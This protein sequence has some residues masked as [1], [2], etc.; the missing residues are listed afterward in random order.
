MNEITAIITF[1]NKENRFKNLEF[2]LSWLE[3]ISTIK[4]II[5][6]EQDS[7]PS[8]NIL[9]SNYSK[10]SYLFFY[11]PTY[12][13]KSI[14][15]N[16]GAKFSKNS[17]LF[18]TDSDIFFDFTKIED[19]LLNWDFDVMSPYS[20]I[21][22]LNLIESNSLITN[23]KIVLDDLDLPFRKEICIAGGSFFI[24]KEKY[25]KNGG[26]NEEF[27]SWG[28]EDDYFSIVLDKNSNNLKTFEQK[29]YHLFHDRDIYSTSTHQF[30]KSN[31]SILATL[32]YLNIKQINT[33][34]SI[35]SKYKSD[36]ESF[37]ECK[38]GDYFQFKNALGQRESS[39]NYSI[40]NT[41]GF[42]GKYQF[43]YERLQDLGLVTLTND[44][45]IWNNGLSKDIFLNNSALQEKVFDLHCIDILEKLIKNYSNFINFNIKNTKLTLSG[46]IAGVH[47]LGF[48][49]LDKRLINEEST[50]DA[51]G[52]NIDNYLEQFS[53]YKICTILD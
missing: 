23:N 28:G 17:K 36:L 16:L 35:S 34:S 10:L 37:V 50:N 22:D 39:N 45:Y 40:V 6:I 32:N 19:E 52:T 33:L 3:N 44:N 48:Q 21:F 11:N 49:N 13:N 25:L 24:S 42:M 2:I 53:G 38:K 5:L 7:I 1:R 8:C 4:E 31:V 14:G 15:F 20:K 43:G 12:F 29:A 18:F 41:L 9:T 30:Y 26:F 27:N 46:M 51:Y 47:L